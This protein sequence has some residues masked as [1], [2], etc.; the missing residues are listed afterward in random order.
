MI[1][2]YLLY[3]FILLLKVPF[4]F[5]CV[6]YYKTHLQISQNNLLSIMVL[7]ILNG[8][9]I[10]TIFQKNYSQH[11]AKTGLVNDERFFSVCHSLKLFEDFL[12]KPHIQAAMCVVRLASL[13]C[14][15]Q[16]NTMVEFIQNNSSYDFHE[17]TIV[18][19]Y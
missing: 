4:Q 13:L 8:E 9:T 19:R 15:K 14:W 3:F 11:N 1:L 18:V 12:H 2:F 6:L 16:H 5:G 7:F 10:L 17:L